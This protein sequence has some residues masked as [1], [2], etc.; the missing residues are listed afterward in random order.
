MAKRAGAQADEEKQAG[1]VALIV[2]PSA[3]EG[4]H[5]RSAD[6]TK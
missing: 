6:Y 5:S 3:S 2:I 4:S 1:F